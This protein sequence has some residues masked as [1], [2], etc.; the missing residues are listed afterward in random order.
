MAPGEEGRALRRPDENPDRGEIGPIALYNLLDQ[1]NP[2]MD[3]EELISLLIID[4]LLV[5]NAYWYKWGQNEQGQ[6]LALY[7]LAPPYV[8]IKPGDLGP[9]GYE[10]TVPDIGQKKPLKM[11][12]NEVLHFKLPNPHDPYYGLG[13]IQGGTRRSTS[14][15]R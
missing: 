4:I 1:P 8:K 13:V 2:Y 5:G 7:R 11:K 3:Y 6:P 14:N 12:L 10:Y 15:W 9:A